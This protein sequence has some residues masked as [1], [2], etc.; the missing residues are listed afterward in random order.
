[1]E[2]GWGYR[3]AKDR[4]WSWELFGCESAMLRTYWVLAVMDQFTRLIGFG[5]HR[6]MVEG[7]ACAGCSSVRLA[8]TVCPNTSAQIT[9]RGINSTNG[10][11]IY[12]ELLGREGRRFGSSR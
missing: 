5:L 1:M 11:P 12:A 9:I 8:G 10:K 2:S 7:V 6:G 3:H 4:W